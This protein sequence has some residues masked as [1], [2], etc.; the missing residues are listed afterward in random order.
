MLEIIIGEVYVRKRGSN[1]LFRKV[2]EIKDSKVAYERIDQKSAQSKRH[3]KN[4]KCGLMSFKI[5]ADG[6]VTKPL[7]TYYGSL[8]LEHYILHNL[9]G[10]PL[11]SIKRKKLD[12]YLRK[13]MAVFRNDIYQLTT[14]HIEESIKATLGT[15]TNPYLL[16][17]KHSQCVVCG[18]EHNL[19][20][21]HVIP[22]NIFKNLPVEIRAHIL[23][24]ILCMCVECHIKIE[25]R[26]GQAKLPQ[27]PKF[28]QID[29]QYLQ[30]LDEWLTYYRNSLI[31]LCAKY[32]P[33][34]WELKL[35]HRLLQ[36]ENIK[37]NHV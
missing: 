16:H 3:S 36:P 33:S 31:P 1:A 6:I 25:Y 4:G 37:T 24:L 30:K 32:I 5:W 15:T 8:K 10:K 26:L 23:G 12:H 19:T 17:K 7:I 22:Q 18:H 27:P 9:E 2:L 20:R 34:S 35:S 21:H 11:L 28:T 29:K 13:G 14:N